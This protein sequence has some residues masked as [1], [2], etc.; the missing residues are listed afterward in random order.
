MNEYI[1]PVHYAVDKN[2]D[3]DTIYKL[4]DFIQQIGD[5]VILYKKVYKVS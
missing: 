1:A 2:Q 5:H 4:P 3:S